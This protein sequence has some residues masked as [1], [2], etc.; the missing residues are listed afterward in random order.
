MRQQQPQVVEPGPD[1]GIS[2]R[3]EVRQLVQRYKEVSGASLSKDSSSSSKN[4]SDS[5]PDSEQ[6]AANQ[7]VNLTGLSQSTLKLLGPT[8]ERFNSPADLVSSGSGS[9]PTMKDDDNDLVLNVIADRLNAAAAKNRSRS[10]SREPS[11]E[12]DAPRSREG[13]CSKPSF[14][15]YLFVMRCIIIYILQVEKL[16]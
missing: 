5:R 3:E 7:K 6:K 12:R 10:R 11:V 16:P 15:V 4:L 9:A 13:Q 8:I 14:C 2:V 1:G